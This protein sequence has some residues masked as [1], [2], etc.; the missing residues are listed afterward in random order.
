MKKRKTKFRRRIQIYTRLGG[1]ILGL[2]LVVLAGMKLLRIGPF[3]DRYFERTGTDIDAHRP[4]IEVEL[5]TVNPYSRPGDEVDRIRGIVIHYTA[6][7]GS[8]AMQNRDY[9]EGLKESKQTMASSHFII[10]L[11]GE[12]VQCI[13]TWEIAYASNERNKDTVSIETCHMTEDGSYTEETYQ[14]M[15]ELTAWLCKKYDLTEDDVIR[16]YDVTGKICP[17][18]FVDYPKEWKK[19]KNDVRI[20]LEMM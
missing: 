19:F 20:R 4:D 1:V 5:L 16:H 13:P 9:F 18:Y 10:G 12:I 8:T 11:E 15:V 7:P 2:M 14:S 17:K 6:N 3:N